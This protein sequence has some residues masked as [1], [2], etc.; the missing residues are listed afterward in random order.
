MWCSPMRRT[1]SPA[2][3]I[4]SL[5]PVMPGKYR[6]IIDEVAIFKVALSEGEIQ[7]IMDDG[8]DKAF[9]VSPHRQTHHHMGI[10]K[11]VTV[12][13]THKGKNTAFLPFFE[14]SPCP[15]P[16][17]CYHTH[18]PQLNLKPNHKAIRDYY[19]TLQQYEQQGITHEGAVS[20]PFDTLLHACAKQINAH[21]HPTI[22]ASARQQ[23]TASSLTG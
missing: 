18:M 12:S 15:I 4:C 2:T 6:G 9:D 22:F 11:A 19:A 8:L 5:V 14:I 1:P 7:S 16:K 13:T 3:L 17:I 20:S 21:L 10:H 23:E